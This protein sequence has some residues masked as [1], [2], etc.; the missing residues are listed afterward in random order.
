MLRSVAAKTLRDARRGFA[1]W[2]AGLV[3]VAAL[4]ISVYP[5]VRDSPAL[6][7]LVKQYPEALKSVVGFGGPLDYASPAG[8]LGAEM[9]SFMIPLLL[10]IATVAAGS[11]AIA[12]EEERGTMELLL[13]L[14][15]TRERLAF[16]KLAAMIAEVV[17]LGAVLWLAL[18]LG[19]VMVDMRI[20]GFHLAAGTA[21]AVLVAIL[22]GALSMAVGAAT[23]RRSLAIG[24]TSAL[25]VAAFLINVL[26]PLVGSLSQV[27][28]LSPFY[29]YA[30]SDPLRQGLEAGDVAF[31]V[32]TAAIVTAAA[33]LAF[34][35][36]DI[37][38]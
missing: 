15:I 10:I 20:S 22:F 31:L 21:G 16:E 7:D 23:G 29:H 19:A 18:W 8:Y 2:S 3:G 13:S 28:R 24:I 12:G 9:F 34:Q 30:A 37:A 26:A 33:M 17:A 35:R 25:A 11:G 36:R 6:N 5:T 1:L 27:R 14:P 38:N 4:M 32:I